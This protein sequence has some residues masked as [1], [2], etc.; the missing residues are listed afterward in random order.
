ML[1][2]KLR[3][4]LQTTQPHNPR[5]TESLCLLTS[6]ATVLAPSTLAEFYTA[7]N[8]VHEMRANLVKDILSGESMEICRLFLNVVNSLNVS[9][10]EP[11][12][13]Q[14]HRKLCKQSKQ[15]QRYR[16]N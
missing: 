10:E 4:L 11:L 16:Y 7:T 6:A 2:L 14:N 1:L 5:I 3:P 15:N 8:S 9:Q 13:L 12:T